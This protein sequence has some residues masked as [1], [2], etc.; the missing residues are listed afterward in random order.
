MLLY[1]LTDNGN[2]TLEL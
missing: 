1:K 2:L